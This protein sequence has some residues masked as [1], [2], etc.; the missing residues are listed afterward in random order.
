LIPPDLL[1]DLD[2]TLCDNFA[3]IAA[4]IGHALQ[5]LDV[6]VPPAT[7][8]RRFVGPPLRSTF[9]ELLGTDSRDRIEEALRHY[10]ERFATLGWRENDVYPGIA[11]ALATLHGTGARLF[12]CTAKPQVYAERIV[13]HFGFAPH[14]TAVYGADLGGRLDDKATLLAH[15]LEREHIAPGRAVMIGDR[16]HDVRAAHHNRVRAIGVLW[17]YGNADELAPADLVVHTPAELTAAL[18]AG[19]AV[20]RGG[21]SSA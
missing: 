11:D 19:T 7:A 17:G 4:C 21:Y 14:F 8:L 10:R 3:G 12:V 1:F 6:P 16:A 18:L 9:A 13:A 20:P 2:G 5:R 15:L